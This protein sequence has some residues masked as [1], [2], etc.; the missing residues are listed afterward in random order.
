MSSVGRNL[1]TTIARLDHLILVSSMDYGSGYDKYKQAEKDVIQT[2][3]LQSPNRC[4]LESKD[5][6]IYYQISD[7]VS[8][9]TLCDRQYPKK[10]AFEYL[11][12]LSTEFQAEYGSSVQRLTRAYAAI[13][14][15][16]IMEKLRTKYIDPNSGHHSLKRLNANLIDIQNIMHQNIKSAMD[17]GDSLDRIE[18]KTGQLLLDSKAFQENA[19]YTNM[20][21]MMKQYAPF[22][23]IGVIILLVL[24][25]RLW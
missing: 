4:I 24:I 10:L 6:L 5:Y 22:V 17:R 20:M 12:E 14:F 19:K 11:Q 3:S 23:A 2:L 7:G 1:I 13:S 21:A 9:V 25:W 18:N 8:Y 16:S 15:E